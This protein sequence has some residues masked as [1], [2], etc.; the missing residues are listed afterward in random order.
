M[1]D[2]PHFFV[3]GISVTFLTTK[4]SRL[5]LKTGIKCIIHDQRDK[6]T[7]NIVTIVS[8]N[9]KQEKI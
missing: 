6:K 5:S 4:V 7:S 9:H 2:F 8:R 1:T 3:Y